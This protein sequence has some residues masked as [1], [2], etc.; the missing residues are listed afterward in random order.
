MGKDSQNSNPFL[1]FTGPGRRRTDHPFVVAT[2]VLL[3]TITA[4]SQ[5]GLLAATI[6]AGS[7][8]GYMV[9]TE[10]LRDAAADETQRRLL[11]AADISQRTLIRV[12][13]HLAK[14]QDEI[15]ECQAIRAA[16]G[17]SR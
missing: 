10:R 4:L 15:K 12:C 8:L 17:L 13:L 16:A 6:W 1:D 11:S 2:I 14:T 7:Q 5:L 3:L 9:R